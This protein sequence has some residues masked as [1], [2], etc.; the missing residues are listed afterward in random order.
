MPTARRQIDSQR[1]AQV[2]VRVRIAVASHQEQEAE[3]GMLLHF[4]HFRTCTWPWRAF[5]GPSQAIQ[6]NPSP[7]SLI[8]VLIPILVRSNSEAGPEGTGTTVCCNPADTARRGRGHGGWCR[9]LLLSFLLYTYL[10]LHYCLI[11]VPSC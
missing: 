11:Q 3:S 9:S 2:Q 1:Q 10:T 5:P 6:A 4:A 8:P 7:D